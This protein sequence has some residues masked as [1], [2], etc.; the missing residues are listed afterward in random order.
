[1]IGISIFSAMPAGTPVKAH[2]SGGGSVERSAS[3][4]I[5][6]DSFRSAF[7]N[8]RVGNVRASFLWKSRLKPFGASQIL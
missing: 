6:L 3:D 1:M 7:S 5:C 4:G 8:R 2:V